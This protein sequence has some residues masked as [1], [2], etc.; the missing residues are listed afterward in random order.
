MSPWSSSTS[1]TST[2]SHPVS[3]VIGVLVV[4]EP[5]QREAEPGA[6]TGL[7]VQADLAAVVLDDLPDHGQAD[8]RA[9]VGRLIVQ[10]L[11]DHEDPVGVL[12]LDPD[13]VVAEREQPV[14]AVP[15]SR[16]RDPRWRLA[17]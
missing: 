1:S 9:G 16:N 4:R 7:G 2:T 17:A 12:G 8:P 14:L 3:S 6:G 10:P 11:T 13:A 5:R 15:L